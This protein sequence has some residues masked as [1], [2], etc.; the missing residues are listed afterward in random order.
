M[1]E[2]KSEGTK[3]IYIVLLV[4]FSILFIS[5]GLYLG[6]I[7]VQQN[8]EQNLYDELVQAVKQD[9]VIAD[10]D[11]NDSLSKYKKL[12]E[13]NNDMVGWI[14][15]PDTNV[16]YPVMQTPDR[17]NYYLRRGFDREYAKMGC[18]FIQENCDINKPSD[19]LIIY[20]H[21]LKSRVMFGDL[22]KYE[23]E[24]FWS[25]HKTI[26]F[27]TLNKKQTYEIISVFKTVISEDNEDNGDEFDFY[28]FVDAKNEQEFND[29]VNEVKKLSLYETGVDAEYGDKLITLATCEYSRPN[30][31]LIVVAKKISA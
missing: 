19:N 14:S 22:I 8:K 16:N 1:K 2:K 28:K 27:D 3:K 12:Y 15:I 17:P 18:P 30:G 7:F 24:K 6:N 10:N 21:N 26:N 29:Y 13:N 11:E 5:S 23:N 20:G 25:E 4:I 31:R 9:D